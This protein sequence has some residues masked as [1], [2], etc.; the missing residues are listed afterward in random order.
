MLGRAYTG[1]CR[2]VIACP[3]K[4]GGLVDPAVDVAGSDF[5]AYW[6]SGFDIKHV[7]FYEGQQPSWFTLRPLTR[8]Q[9]DAL[10]IAFGER[11]SISWYLRCG[12]V[13][14][15]NYDLVKED[16]VR[17]GAPQPEMERRGELG[18]V[19][20]EKWLDEVN[21]PTDQ[22]VAL[23]HA[24]NKITEPSLPLSMPSKP[25]SGG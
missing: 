15:E 2:I 18:E 19:A 22:R 6:E 4:Y 7:A 8:R 14:I 10:D 24:I 23:F 12:I 16:G 25:Q 17:A 1:I 5:D 11:S 3:P 9:R 20:S 21:F 13:K